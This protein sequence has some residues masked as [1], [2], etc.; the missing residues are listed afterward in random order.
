MPK[1]PGCRPGGLL[2]A[3]DAVFRGDEAAA[4]PSAGVEPVSE[5][6][7][8]IHV[9]YTFAGQR[10]ARAR[11][12]IVWPLT[13]ALGPVRPPGPLPNNAPCGAHIHTRN[14]I[15]CCAKTACGLWVSSY[16]ARQCPQGWKWAR[17]RGHETRCGTSKRLSGT[18]ADAC[19]HS[20]RSVFWKIVTVVVAQCLAVA[21]LLT[22]AQSAER[23]ANLDRSHQAAGK[24]RFV[25]TIVTMRAQPN[26]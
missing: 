10:G 3:A 21:L 17:P 12:A 8:H 4:G 25:A 11:A 22:R 19:K 9:Y 15:G 5:V 13:S 14:A 6:L 18:R 23:S 7:L 26:V 2:H 20:R 16:C 24:L 1:A